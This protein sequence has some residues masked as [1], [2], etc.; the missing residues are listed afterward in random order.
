MLMPK[1]GGLFPV[2]D[3][4]RL[5]LVELQVGVTVEKLPALHGLQQQITG[6]LAD[7]GGILG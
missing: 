1:R 4:L 2:D 7:A 3:D 5:R 6:H